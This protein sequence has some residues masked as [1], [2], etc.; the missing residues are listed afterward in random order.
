MKFLWKE[1]KEGFGLLHF[2][3]KEVEKC[4]TKKDKESG[5]GQISYKGGG[6]KNQEDSKGGMFCLV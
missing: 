2:P 1:G 4:G 3:P 5:M 6:V